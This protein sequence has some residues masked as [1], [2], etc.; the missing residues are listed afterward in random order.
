MH[1]SQYNILNALVVKKTYIYIYM[2]LLEDKVIK[3]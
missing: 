3:S 1:T 2:N